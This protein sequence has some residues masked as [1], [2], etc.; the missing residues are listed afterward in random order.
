MNSTNNQDYNPAED[1]NQGVITKLVQGEESN[2]GVSQIEY[3]NP[4]TNQ[5]PEP[6][7]EE[8]NESDTGTNGS[9]DDLLTEKDVEDGDIEMDN[10]TDQ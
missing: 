10:E 5:G 2:E 6:I 9:N 7:K 8:V 3:M 4:V 1:E